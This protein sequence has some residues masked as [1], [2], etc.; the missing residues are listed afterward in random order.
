MS[1]LATAWIKELQTIAGDG[2]RA[3]TSHDT[4]AG[5]MPQVVV[6]PA[7]EAGIAAVLSF[8]DGQGLK[9]L[10][11]GG[12]TQ[13]G[14]GNPPS[15]DDILLNLEHLDRVIA[16][17]PHDMT[18]TVQAGLTLSVLQRQLADAR[19][20]L[21]LDAVL[22]EGATIGGIIATNATG[23]RRLRYGGVRDQIIGVQVVLADGTIAK[24]GGQVVKN[25]AGYD[26]PKL[27]TSSLGTLG[28]ITAATF[29]LYPLSAFSQ[30]AIIESLPA[31][32]ACAIAQQIAMSPLTPTA[33]DILG[34]TAHEHCALAVRFESGSE[35][36]VA[37]QCA[38]LSEIAHPTRVVQGVEESTFW[39]EADAA[40]ATQAAEAKH[41]LAKGNMLR[42]D[43]PRW[44]DR[45]AQLAQTE[46]TQAFWRAHAGHGIIFTQLIGIE[47][48][49]VEVVTG[50][51]ASA[52]E[53][54][55]SLVVLDMSPELAQQIDAWGPTAALEMMRRIKA[56]FDPHGTLNPGRFVG[57][58]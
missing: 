19:Q 53:R 10:V 56:Q 39:A 42:T 25:V 35:E 55:G 26:L 45:L 28:V 33:L 49:L 8:A 18:V 14:L 12:G 20:W 36:A 9:V 57:G 7:D 51:R 54:S 32:E 58:I 30:T 15:G 47:Q 38:A 3:A 34:D 1:Q 52:I 2:V 43:I 11:R 27:F 48:A 6:A 21:A 46:K 41:V 4:V 17:A 23:A 40:L 22:S 31:P 44:L 16:H 24:G 50:L 13:S 5:V 29:R 37:E